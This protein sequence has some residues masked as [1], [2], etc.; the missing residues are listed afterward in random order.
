MAN[1]SQ[2]DYFPSMLSSTFPGL[3]FHSL[4]GA[5]PALANACPDEITWCRQGGWGVGDQGGLPPMEK[6]ELGAWPSLSSSQP[7]DSLLLSCSG[8]YETSQ[9]RDEANKQMSFWVCVCVCVHRSTEIEEYTHVCV[10]GEL[11]WRKDVQWLS[12]SKPWQTIRGGEAIVG[13]HPP[14][15]LCTQANTVKYTHAHTHT[16]TFFPPPPHSQFQTSAE[17]CAPL[18]HLLSKVTIKDSECVRM[19][20]CEC[21]CVSVFSE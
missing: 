4:T 8:P 17:S 21:V 2:N 20:L 18:S 16:S 1:P 11:S 10:G 5:G 12:S 19:R 3:P 14:L 9:Y 13:R 15:S 6:K 7:P